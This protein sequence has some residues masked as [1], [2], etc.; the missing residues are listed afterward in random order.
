MVQKIFQW[1]TLDFYSLG[2]VTKLTINTPYID[3]HSLGLGDKRS[4][5][6]ILIDLKVL[7]KKLEVFI[8]I[9][10]LG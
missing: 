5:I 4:L 9:I 3:Y 7:A 2:L 8:C 1:F 6:F 10:N